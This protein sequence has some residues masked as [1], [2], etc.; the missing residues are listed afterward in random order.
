MIKIEYFFILITLKYGKDL[1]I[2]FIKLN[3]EK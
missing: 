1:I 3:L 2:A